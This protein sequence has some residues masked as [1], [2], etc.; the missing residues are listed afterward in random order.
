P[1]YADLSWDRLGDQGLQWDAAQARPEPSYQPARQN[2]VAA[3]PEY[4]LALVSGTVLYDGGTMFWI[5]EELRNMAVGQ[6]V[7]VNPAD[8]ERMALEPGT[9]VA[10]T[11]PEGSLDLTVIVNEGVKPGTAW[12]PESLPGAP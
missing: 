9:P 3:S 5:T 11:S 6:V 10:V 2:E 1:M 8:A 12:I 7:A 4:P